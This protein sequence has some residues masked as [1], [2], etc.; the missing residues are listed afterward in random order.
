[1]IKFLK[2]L[3]KR[4]TNSGTPHRLKFI[5]PVGSLSEKAAKEN[6]NALISEYKEEIKWD[7]ETGEVTINGNTRV[8][9]ERE[10]WL[11]SPS[12]D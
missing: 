6:I 1:M 9:F 5:I 7:D 8:P 4:Q 3:V 2:N 11:P 12:K 10:I